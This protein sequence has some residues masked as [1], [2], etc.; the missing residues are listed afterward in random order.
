MPPGYEISL[1]GDYSDKN[2]VK[3]RGEIL[4]SADGLDAAK[5]RAVWVSEQLGLN[6]Y[7]SSRVTGVIVEVEGSEARV[8]FDDLD[9]N[10]ME[11]TTPF[12][13]LS[14][15]GVRAGKT[16]AKVG[17]HV[18]CQTGQDAKWFVSC[19]LSGEP[20]LQEARVVSFTKGEANVV[21]TG[22]PKEVVKGVVVRARLNGDALKDGFPDIDVG[23]LVAVYCIKQY[24]DEDVKPGDIWD[25]HHVIDRVK[26]EVRNDWGVINR[27][28]LTGEY[29]NVKVHSEIEAK[30]GD[31]FMLDDSDET[32]F[33]TELN[34][35]EYALRNKAVR[36]WQM[37]EMANRR[38]PEREYRR[39]TNPAGVQA[40]PA[41][42]KE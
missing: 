27:I 36:L 32:A 25:I 2:V 34:H 9:F 1:N 7:H 28:C 42:R 39:V 33:R 5:A 21:L 10:G 19:L 14:L 18:I 4:D 38:L 37:Q 35:A 11:Y 8:K 13:R 23:D 31:E 12:I 30:D 40:A 17:D 24:G 16:I 6:I 41:N 15:A 3:F 20:Q 29:R 26:I 22:V